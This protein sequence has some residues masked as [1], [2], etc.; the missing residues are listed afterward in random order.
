MRTLELLAPARNA[1][2]ARAAILHGADAVYIG[3]PKFGARAAAGNSLDELTELVKFAHLYRAKVYVTL[4]TI[5][6]DDEIQEARSIIESL[7]RIGADAL[8]VQDMGIFELDL[9][10]IALHAST[11]C[12]NRT[13]EKVQ[14]LEQIGCEQVVLARE[15]SLEDIRQIRQ[16][17]RVR[18]EAFVHGA[19]CVSYSGQCYAGQALAG[20]SANRGVCPQICRLPF[21]VQDAEGHSLGQQH[22]LSLNDLDTHHMLS[23]L[24]VAGVDSFTMVG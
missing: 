12:D 24:I 1:E 19:L 6:T 15:L 21:D 18:L 13:A 22:W 8:I 14:F 5:L 11:Q 23:E 2:I 9:P 7:Y 17:T 20:R 10:P 4:N 16:N 3:A